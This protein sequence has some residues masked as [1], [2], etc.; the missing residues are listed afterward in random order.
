MVLRPFL[1]TATSC[2][3]TS[4]AACPQQAGGGRPARRAGRRLLRYGRRARLSNHGRLRPTATPGQG[5]EPVVWL[6]LRSE[7]LADR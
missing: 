4:S 7:R 1:N 3:S 2:A 5:A 6:S